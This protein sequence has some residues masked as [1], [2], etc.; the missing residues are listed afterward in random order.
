MFGNP[1][2]RR[3]LLEHAVDV[4]AKSC[5]LISIEDAPQHCVAECLELRAAGGDGFVSES[6]VQLTSDHTRIL[7][8]MSIVSTS[9]RAELAGQEIIP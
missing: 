2:V 8:V 3:E 5:Y 9:E 7:S 4:G 6:Q 1:Y